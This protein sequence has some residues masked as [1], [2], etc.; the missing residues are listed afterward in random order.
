MSEGPT[1]EEI[2]KAMIKEK[3]AEKARETQKAKKGCLVASLILVSWCGFCVLVTEPLEWPGPDGIEGGIVCAEH[4]RAQLKSPST[5]DFPWPVEAILVGS[6]D[7]PLAEQVWVVLSYVNAQN[8]FG[9]T[10]RTDYACSLKPP[11]SQG[12]EWTVMNIRFDE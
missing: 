11:T 12:G 8:T 2:A 4:A 1:A 10:I 5:A 9:A 7:Q 3:N 6:Q